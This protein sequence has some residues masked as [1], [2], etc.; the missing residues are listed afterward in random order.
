M[1]IEW[2]AVLVSAIDE[3]GKRCPEK[4]FEGRLPVVGEAVEMVFV[5]YT[6]NGDMR[7]QYRVKEGCPLS[8]NGRHWCC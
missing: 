6:E 2:T 8:M 5:G 3:Y 4:F 1:T 7:F